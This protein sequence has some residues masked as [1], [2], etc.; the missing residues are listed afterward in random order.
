MVLI[1]HENLEDDP[2]AYRIF[3]AARD[4]SPW[5]V[6]DVLREGPLTADPVRAELLW[7]FA[8]RGY[9]S[10][11]AGLVAAATLAAFTEDAPL[12]FGLALA[13]ADE[14]RHA[15]ALYQYART[16]G[17][18]PEDCAEL[19]QPL[20]DA[21]VAL[22]HMG[23]VLVHT[24]LEGV[25]AD[26]FHLL[27]QQFADDA[28]GRL[29]GFIRRDEVLHVAIGLNYLTRESATAAG[30]ETWRA[31]AAHWHEIGMQFTYLDQ[32][33]HLHADLVGW[34]PAALKSW[35]LRRHYTRLRAAGIELGR[36]GEAI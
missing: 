12:R 5:R 34:P 4:K 30:R 11:Q 17:G 26:E 23:R 33:A 27:R 7:K 2:V 15:D 14:A 25:A 29:Y 28:L 21:L 36:G 35:F 22:P 13:V 10:E 9:Y 8:S 6:A 19:L 16:I 1:R 20:D 32:L 18:E 31:H 3:S 24:L